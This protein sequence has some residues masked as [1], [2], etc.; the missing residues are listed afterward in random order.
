MIGLERFPDKQSFQRYQNRLQTAWEQFMSGESMTPDLSVLSFRIAESWKRS[1]SYGLDPFHY[2]SYI[3]MQKLNIKS[4]E[5]QLLMANEVA[6]YWYG[7]LSKKYAFNVSIFDSLGN[8]VALLPEKD[9]SLSFANE[10]ILGTNAAALALLENRSG[11]VLAQEHYSRFFH[12]RFCVAAPFHSTDQNVVGTIC[13]STL[14]FEIIHSLSEIAEQ[15]AEICTLLFNLSH[16]VPNDDESFRAV[17]ANISNLSA[18]ILHMDDW[19]KIQSLS[20]HAQKLTTYYKE[21]SSTGSAPEKEPLRLHLNE[22]SKFDTSMAHWQKDASAQKS[23][24]QITEQP[25]L[26]QV[27]PECSMEFSDIVGTAPQLVKC[28]RFAK[29]AA[30]TDFA[31]VLNGESGTG[32]DILA[33]AIHNA[34]PR[35]NGPF[36]ALNCGA[37]ASDLVE[38]ELFGYEKGAFTG[39]NSRGKIGLMER[40]SGGTLF[41]DE[42]E[43]MPLSI[44]AKLLRVLSSGNLSRV[45]ATMEIP[46]DL[47]I[48]SASKVDLRK[49]SEQGNF[50]EDLFFRISVVSLQ[51]P[52]LRDRKEDIP[53]LVQNYLSRIGRCSTQVSQNAMAALCAFNWPGNVREL[54]NVLIHAC[55][56]SQKGTISIESLPDE[57]QCAGQITNILHFL[58]EH[59]LLT[60]QGTASI[61]QIEVE[62][63]QNALEKSNFL[64]KQTAQMLNI[65]RK[66]L[67]RK[68]KQNPQLVK[69]VNGHFGEGIHV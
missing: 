26:K 62:L 32:K 40:A 55:I 54:E 12:Q 5:K 56:F 21:C 20:Q 4:R 28:I 9:Y 58:K 39:A 52:P 46:V 23:I 57:L 1:H 30:V 35:R 16:Q 14:D 59:R 60:D 66:T 15:F 19:E 17:L 61:S 42:I 38:S 67:C 7:D 2:Q 3:K 50:R 29:Q 51:I 45:G 36:V 43:S 47:R 6:G 69:L 25:S 18:P 13:L 22:N 37:I 8:D 44:Q 68:I 65:D 33:Q 53:Q 63:I 27:R 10:M 31:I 49:A 24:R 34:S 11:C 48:I 64:L 41:L